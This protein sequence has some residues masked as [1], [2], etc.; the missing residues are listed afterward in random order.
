M[1]VNHK[2][3][4]D[5]F[6]ALHFASFRGNVNMI[7]LLLENGADMHMRNNFGINVL[8]VAAQGDQP[9]SLYFFKEKGI[10]INSKD[11]RN[12]TPMHWA[13]YSRSEIAL[14]YLLSWVKDLDE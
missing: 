7:K 3:E 12:S 8:H 10:D 9:I 6:I 11:N 2:T 4:E 1:W 14:C 13:C 5:G